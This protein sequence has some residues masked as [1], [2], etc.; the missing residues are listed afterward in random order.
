M[1]ETPLRLGILGL[2]AIGQMHVRCAIGCDDIQLIGVADVDEQL[3]QRATPWGVPVHADLAALLNAAPDAVVVATPTAL[4]AEHAVACMERGIAVLV[5]K[6]IADTAAAAEVMCA[7]AQR[8]G[9]VLL[10]GHQ[11]RHDP[12]LQVA[13]ASIERGDIGRVVWAHASATWFKPD[14]YFDQSWRRQPGGGPVLINAIH[15]IDALRF[16]LGDVE[17][18]QAMSSSTV[19]GHAVEDTAVLTLR[20][21][22]GALATVTVSDCSVSPW[23]WDLSARE[24][25]HYPAVDEDAV[26]LGGVEGSLALPSLTVWHHEGR[27][28][29]QEPLTRTRTMQRSHDPYLAQLQHLKAVIEARATPLCSGRDACTSLVT[30]LAALE[31]ARSRSPVSLSAFFAQQKGDT[32][33]E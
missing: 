13:R 1:G 10:V 4:H 6:P 5:E 22:C 8:H 11:R 18:V 30:T 19:R 24:A 23:N 31:S 17:E 14:A 2:G 26:Y 29:W 15:D 3:R 32:C 27:K 16:L 20:F 33:R 7:T 12:V 28:G 25:A 9:A 21:A